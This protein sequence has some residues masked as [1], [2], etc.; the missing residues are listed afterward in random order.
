MACLSAAY[1]LAETIFA[2]F[3][4]YQVHQVRSRPVQ[5]QS[6]GDVR[7]ALIHKI[8]A[9]DHSP[10]IPRTNPAQVGITRPLEVEVSCE[11]HDDT[12]LGAERDFKPEDEKVGLYENSCNSTSLTCRQQGIETVKPDQARIRPPAVPDARAVEFR[13]RLRTWQVSL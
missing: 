5:A 10:S 7:S 4:L 8:L 2:I 1:A 12:S 11:T 13:E 9:L 6:T 3:H